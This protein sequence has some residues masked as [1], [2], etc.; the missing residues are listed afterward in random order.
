MQSYWVFHPGLPAF[1]WRASFMTQ[2][3]SPWKRFMHFTGGIS[4][5]L[6]WNPGDIVT[7]WEIG[8]VE[9]ALTKNFFPGTCID[10]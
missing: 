1:F 3:I 7:T 4:M 8:G 6:R 5:S 9:K 2:K 10:R